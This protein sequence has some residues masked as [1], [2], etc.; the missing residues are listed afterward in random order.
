MGEP[1]IG[2]IRIFANAYAPRGWAFCDGQLMSIGQ[3]TT[4]FSVISTF[5]GGDGRVN[6]ALPDLR[7][8]VPMH[9]GQGP[10]LNPYYIS[11]EGGFSEISLSEYHMPNHTHG[12]TTI[13]KNPDT[14]LPTNSYL[15]N[16]ESVLEYKKPPI[17]QT[18]QMSTQAIARTGN[19]QGHENKQPY[20]VLNFC[21][22]LEGMYPSR[23]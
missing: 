16:Y 6:F 1:F 19:S 10:G 14:P 13:L 5:Y 8:K 9:W 7:G 18:V 17:L 12:T 2:E 15:G 4:L 3:N 23:S 22:A 11:Q 20:T 21:I